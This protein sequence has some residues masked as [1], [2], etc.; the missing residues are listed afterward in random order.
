MPI[1]LPKCDPAATL[2]TTLRRFHL[3]CDSTA[4]RQRLFRSL[5]AAA[6]F[7]R[8][9]AAVRL[10]CTVLRRNSVAY[11]IAECAMTRGG[12]RQISRTCRSCFVRLDRD[13]LFTFWLARRAEPS[14]GAMR[15]IR[16]RIPILAFSAVALL[17]TTPHARPQDADRGQIEFLLNCASCHGIDAKGSG[18]QS[19][20]LHISPPDLTALA[21]LNHG[22]FD[23]GAVYQMIDGR[24]PRMSHHSAEMPIWGCRHQ[25][26]LP[27]IST[28][29]KRKQ[30]IP[31]RIVSQMKPHESE[32]DSLLDLPCESEAAT[33][34]RLLAIVSYLSLVQAK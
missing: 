6:A 7:A 2:T 10:A 30:K 27:A 14:G 5:L 23:P 12:S 29:A 8:I 9:I 21:K 28:T 11:Q 1:T 3:R 32:L 18:P 16:P 31:K 20:K 22:R 17:A 26:P 25:T 19:V 33:R 24:N 34:E 15:T 13:I 4:Q